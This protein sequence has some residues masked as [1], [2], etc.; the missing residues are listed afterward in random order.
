MMNMR[1]ERQSI[2]RLLLLLSGILIALGVAL[3]GFYLLLQPPPAPLQEIA[4]YLATTALMSVVVAYLLVRT[5]LLTRSPRLRWTL[6]TITAVA[7]IL[8][9]ANVWLPARWLALDAEALIPLV[10]LVIF[11][12]LITASVTLY[13]VAPLNANIYTL[14]QAGREVTRGR[15]ATRALLTGRDETA[16]VARS[17]NFLTTQLE[18]TLR[19]QQEMEGMRRE[20]VTWVGHDLRTPLASVHAIIQSL[21]DN[22]VEDPVTAN[23]YLRTAQRDLESLTSLVDDL[24]EMALINTGGLKVERKPNSLS[25]LLAASVALFEEP[26]AHKSISIEVTVMPGVDPVVMDAERIGRVLF[27]LLENALRYT[28][29]GGRVTVRASPIPEGVSVDVSDNGEGIAP[30]DLPRIFDQFFRAETTRRR[31]TGG[32]GLGLAIARGIVEAH[33][34]RITVQSVLNQGTTVSFRIPQTAHVEV[35]NPLR[36]WRGKS[37]DANVL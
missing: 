8:T 18:Q 16:E 27:S 15:L 3:A 1:P 7:G 32:A 35:R 25:D 2:V 21:A 6:I 11:S 36:R 37:V 23:R 30:D 13:L 28:P 24:Y 14:A 12:A 9:V 5:G 20:L 33:G 26:A 31:S 17:F 29:D 4:L 22:L 19:R 10:L 34:G